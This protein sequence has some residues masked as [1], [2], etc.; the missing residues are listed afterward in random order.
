VQ[1]EEKTQAMYGMENI[2]LVSLNCL[3]RAKESHDSC[4]NSM[5][6]SVIITAEPIRNMYL[7]IRK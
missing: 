6:P 3:A 1:Q 7:Q 2:V 4:G 5:L